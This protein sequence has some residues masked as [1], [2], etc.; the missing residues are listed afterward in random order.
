[1]TKFLSSLPGSWV[2]KDRKGQTWHQRF[3][4][5]QHVS[6]HRYHRPH[7]HRHHHRQKSSSLVIIIGKNQA[8]DV[9]AGGSS[10]GRVQARLGLEG[11]SSKQRWSG[12]FNHFE[13]H[14]GHRPVIMAVA[15]Q[16]RMVIL[17]NDCFMWDLTGAQRRNHKEWSQP[18]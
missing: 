15:M 10:D 14:D 9:R 6:Y 16:I 18:R 11:C 7:C 17:E 13:Y 12:C 8:G 3:S 5:S 1:M 2:P 4:S